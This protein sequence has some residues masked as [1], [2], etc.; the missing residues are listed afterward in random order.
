M[1]LPNRTQTLL[2]GLIATILVGWVLSIGAA[3]I[4]PIVIALLL[5]IMLQPVVVILARFGIPPAATV[6]AITGGLFMGL[7]Q[8]GLVLQSNVMSFVGLSSDSIPMT[9]DQN[10]GGWS[11]IVE[12]LTTRIQAWELP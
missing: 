9:S 8:L 11:Q 7:V 1:A 2:L 12:T 6:V 3:I 5:A 10:V 4:Q